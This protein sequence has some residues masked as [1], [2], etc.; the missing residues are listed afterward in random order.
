MSYVR[1]SVGLLVIAALG[2]ALAPR[3]A[4]SADPCAR[5]LAFRRGADGGAL[6]RARALCPASRPRGG[7]PDAAIPSIEGPVTGGSRGGPFISATSFDLADVGYRQDEFF[8]SGPATA[9]ANVGPLGS[10]GRWSVTAAGTADY[11]TRIVV[12]RPID[13]KDFNGTVAVEWLNVSGGLDAAPDWITAHTEMIREGYAWVGVSAQFVGV[14][15][16]GSIAP[17]LGGL[18][19]TDPER[20]GSLVHPGDSFSYDIFSQA[21]Q[22]VRGA[23]SIDPLDGL[24]PKRVIALGESQSA[25]RLVT[26]INA[27]DPRDR[28]YDGY[29]VHSRGGGSAPLSQA[30][31]PAIDAPEVVLFRDDV[32][33]P[34]MLLQT[35]TDLINLGYLPDRQPDGRLFRLWE[36][37]GTS[38]ADVYTLGVGFSDVGGDPV[39]AE[40]VE[41]SSPIPGIIDCDR[42]V[43]SGPQHFVVKA[44]L[45]A[46]ERWVATG[47]TPPRA[48]RLEVAGEEFVL[49][50]FGNVRGGIR[51]SYVDVP[52]ATLSG[53]GQSGGGFCF[54][55]GTTELFDEATLDELYP[56]HEAYVAAVDEATDR[57]VRARFVLRPD[58]EL[59]VEAAERSDVG[60]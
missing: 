53:L 13:P 46:L 23:S 33:V 11:K 26:Y 34:V 16:M 37:A 43:N 30:P 3:P 28:V 4:A 38:H 7:G 40:V 10:D 1:R 44:A 41:V 19:V 8:I 27:I 31:E 54:I 57:A 24:R 12:Y 18:K 48:P 47:A 17:G 52:I 45:H 22:A 55:F 56:D 59:I 2:I 9:Y 58:A 51:T 14:E 35:E 21:G 25:F 20:Y 42:P 6:D 29:F 5:R 36:V 49:D 50:E 60:N 32:R 15:G 39:V